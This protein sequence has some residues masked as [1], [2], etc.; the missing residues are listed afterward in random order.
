MRVEFFEINLDD[1][2]KRINTIASLL[3]E[4]A[5]ENGLMT[6]LALIHIVVCSQI[7]MGADRK[8]IFLN[9]HSLIQKSLYLSGVDDP[10][11]MKSHVFETKKP[12]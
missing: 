9:F 5:I 7:A 10:E 6:E 2:K 3:A 4:S 11:N 1:L 12:C 8:C